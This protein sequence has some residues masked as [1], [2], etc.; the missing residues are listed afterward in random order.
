LM[1]GVCGMGT[2][3]LL[4]RFGLLF[5]PQPDGRANDIR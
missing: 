2:L 4:S 3:H 1:H 5:A